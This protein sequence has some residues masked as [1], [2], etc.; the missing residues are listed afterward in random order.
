MVKIVKLC[1]DLVVLSKHL[2]DAEIFYIFKC[3]KHIF[4]VEGFQAQ[5]Y[6]T[7]QG[8]KAVH[9]MSSL[10]DRRLFTST[11]ILSLKMK[12]CLNNYPGLVEII[13]KIHR[14]TSLVALS[15]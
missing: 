12:K 1:R 5:I 11:C 6:V 3:L 4:W 7:Q 9:T 14:E 15:K 10:R 2:K 13:K 8:M